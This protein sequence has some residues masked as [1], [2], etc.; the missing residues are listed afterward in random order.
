[1][2]FWYKG[3]NG[4]KNGD[5]WTASCKGDKNGHKRRN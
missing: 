1:M 4:V 3:I 2:K 5:F